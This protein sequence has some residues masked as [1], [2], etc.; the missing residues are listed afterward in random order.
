MAMSKRFDAFFLLT[1]IL[2]LVFG[3]MGLSIP[4]ATL[5]LEGLGAGFG[6]ISLILASSAAVGLV[7]SY[8][9]G[10]LSDRWG[11]RKPLIVGGL[12]GM[13]I[14]YFLL[15]QATTPTQAW[16]ARLWEGVVQGSYF[17]TSLA[18]M[19]DVLA[20]RGASGRGKG[21]GSYRGVGSLTFAAGAVVG[22][23]LAD[24]FSLNAVFAVAA[25]L[26]GLAA[27][28]AL[29]L[30]EHRLSVASPP[31]EPSPAPV[32]ERRRAPGLPAAFLGGVLL[33]TSAV[34]AFSSMSSNYLAR[35]GYS[36]ATI[37]TLWALAALVEAPVM[38]WVGELSDLIGR[39][40]VLAFG[41]VTMVATLVGFVLLAASLTS[42][43]GVHILRGISYGSL[44]ATS[45]VYTAEAGDRRTRGHNSGLY[46]AAT[47]AGQLLGLVLGGT[48]VQARGFEF[49]FWV[50]AAAAAASGLCFLALPRKRAGDD[51]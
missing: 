38:R 45:M 35:L 24:Q 30:H 4:L 11:R 36:K 48:L 18:L 10:R 44:M 20:R 25:V 27:L 1:V 47:G 3:A 51:E 28:I 39:V 43:V 2:G 12:A 42:L 41:S 19:G 21:M 14:A 23:R 15:S 29:T 46:T 9:W 6:R 7:G 16:G 31:P 33:W 37:T 49:L 13:A 32:G 34:S 26:Y 5:F 40:P 8:A 50:C 22:G 17:T